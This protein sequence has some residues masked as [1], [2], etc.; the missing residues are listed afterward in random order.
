[1]SPLSPG[2]RPYRREANLRPAAVLVPTRPRPSRP[3]ASG[4]QR[5]LRVWEPVPP[6]LPTLSA[7]EP[8]RPPA[9]RP[10]WHPSMGPRPE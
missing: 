4:L 3:T 9:P 8:E 2:R 5:L 1:M 10:G 7:L 6:P